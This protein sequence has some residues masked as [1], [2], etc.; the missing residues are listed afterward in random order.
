MSNE[1]VK[2]E[3]EELQA[4][5]AIAEQET[6]AVTQLGN[7]E[8]QLNALKNQKELIFNS[9]KELGNKRIEHM[10]SLQEKYGLGTINIDTG[11]FTSTE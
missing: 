11:E 9:I 7:V 3:Q 6:T 5:R 1:N 8:F 4:I 2:L 10:N